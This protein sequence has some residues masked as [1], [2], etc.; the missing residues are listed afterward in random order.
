MMGK[1]LDGFDYKEM[2]HLSI[3]DKDVSDEISV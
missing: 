1:P 3:Q 2:E